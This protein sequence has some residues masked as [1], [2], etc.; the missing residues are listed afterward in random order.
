M[1]ERRVDLSKYRQVQ[2][3]ESFQAAEYCF[4]KINYIGIP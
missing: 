3:E 4:E 2:A 1:D